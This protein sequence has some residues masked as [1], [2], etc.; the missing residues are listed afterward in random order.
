MKNALG[1]HQYEGEWEDDLPN[2]HGIE[3]LA[4]QFK[5]DGNFK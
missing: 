1:N 4:G 3:I 2:G 5:Y